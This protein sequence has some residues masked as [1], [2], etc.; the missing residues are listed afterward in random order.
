V[1]VIVS[2][3]KTKLRFWIIASLLLSVFFIWELASK[4]PEDLRRHDYLGPATNICFAILC[5]SG[6]WWKSRQL[7]SVS[8][9][10]NAAIWVE[11]GKIYFPQVVTGH[12]RVPISDI[13]SFRNANDPYGDRGIA[14]ALR[15]G[16]QLRMHIDSLSGSDDEI[17]ARLRSLLPEPR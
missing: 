12:P 10:A 11:N 15:D 7:R 4:L 3:S 9:G 2:F 17:L 5:L 6:L 16:R 1:Q 14:V 8:G 13:E